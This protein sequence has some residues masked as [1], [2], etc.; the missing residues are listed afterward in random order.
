M[1][2]ANIDKVFLD[3]KPIDTPINGTNLNP[4]KVKFEGFT[5]A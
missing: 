2:V 5:Y 4:Q 3:E 1:S